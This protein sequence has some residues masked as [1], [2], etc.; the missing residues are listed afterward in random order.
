MRGSREFFQ[1][2]S[3]FFT[4]LVD[5]EREDPT[6]TLSGPLS[7]RQQN[8]IQMAFRCQADGGPTLNAGL[9]AAIFRGSGPVLLENPIFCDFSEGGVRTPFTPPLDPHMMVCDISCLYS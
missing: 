5:L 4:F 6:T 7:A 9:V 2:G 1:R 3:N 8:A